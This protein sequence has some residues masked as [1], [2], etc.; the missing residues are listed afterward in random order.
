MRAEKP[1]TRNPVLGVQ[2]FVATVRVDDILDPDS[3]FQS[4]VEN[5]DPVRVVDRTAD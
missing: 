5:L 1:G 2:Q 3:P 4:A